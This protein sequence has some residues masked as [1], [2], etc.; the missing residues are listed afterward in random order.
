MSIG[1]KFSTFCSNLRMSDNVVSNVQYRYKR[2]TRQLNADFRNINSDT[3]YS[4]YVGSYGRGTAI[5]VSDIDMIIEL[6]FAVYQQYNHYN[7]NGQS[8][9]LQTVRNSIK[10]TYSTTHISGDGQVIQLNFNDG[11]S[12]E[13]VPGFINKDK[14][15]FTYPDTNNGGAWKCTNPRAEINEMKNG[16]NLWNCNLKRLCRMVRAWKDQWSVPI[17]GLLIDTFAYNFLKQ[18]KYRDKAFNYYDWMTRDFF[19]YLKQQ[20]PKKNYWL[21]VGSNQYVYCK[22]NFEY[23]ALLCYN[24]SIEALNFQSQNQYWSANQKWREIYGTK[25]PH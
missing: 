23:K 7:G 9:L 16:D 5:H 13:I 20:D 6:P 25:F 21:A 15:S 4:L 22:G 1:D 11:I 8:A 12:Y 19:Q 24:L 2:I 17:G 3:R 18:W 14:Q 10:K